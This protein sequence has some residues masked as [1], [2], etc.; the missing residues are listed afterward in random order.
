MKTFKEKAKK[1]IEEFENT[2]I[3]SGY[4]DYRIE[5]E[6]CAL[7]CISKQI[8]LLRYLSSKTSEELLDDLVK[9]K[10]EIKDNFN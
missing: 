7:I 2:E 10:Q 1:L 8:E 6:Q 4:E 9:Q 5:A 3:Q